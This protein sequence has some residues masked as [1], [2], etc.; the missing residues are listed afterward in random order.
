MKLL[1]PFLYKTSLKF[2][3]ML[4]NSLL[5]NI[6][7]SSLDIFWGVEIV[8]LPLV[9][10]CKSEHIKM[11]VNFPFIDIF[12]S[13]RR[14][15]YLFIPQP[16]FEKGVTLI[17]S[18]ICAKSVLSK[19]LLLKSSI[20]SSPDF[21]RESLIKNCFILAREN[22]KYNSWWCTELKITDYLINH[23]P[24]IASSVNTMDY[25]VKT[26]TAPICQFTRKFPRRRKMD[27]KGAPLRHQVDAIS[28][29]QD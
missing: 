8:A 1:F 23:R 5:N 25:L 6:P 20:S 19:Y 2:E 29:C 21:N 10:W 18:W 4:K 15:F 14:L 24:R 17:L 11:R 27:A 12:Q 9:A 26:S 13:V 7:F 28:I 3:F 16:S 22:F